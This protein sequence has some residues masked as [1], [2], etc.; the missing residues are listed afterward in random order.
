MKDKLDKK[1][2]IKNQYNNK[3]KSNQYI[4]EKI[5]EAHIKQSH[6]HEVDI[7]D[8]EIVSKWSITKNVGSVF[9]F[10]CCKKTKISE[11]NK[12]IGIGSSLFLLSLKSY[13]FLFIILS[14]LSIPAC[15]VLS[16]GTEVNSE[17]LSGNLWGLLSRASLGNIGYKKSYSCDHINIA[18][19]QIQLNL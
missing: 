14:I 13:I 16:S 5:L 4:S 11:F 2:I 12:N 19:M 15:I 3:I 1:D 8:E 18:S 6:P 7:D 9:D 17:N 10:F